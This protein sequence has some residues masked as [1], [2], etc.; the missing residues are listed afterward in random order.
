MES[1]GPYFHRCGTP[2]EKSNCTACAYEEGRKSMEK[3][4]FADE[5]PNNIKIFIQSSGRVVRILIG[6]GYFEQ[7]NQ[8]AAQRILFSEIRKAITTNREAAEKEARGIE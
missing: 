6:E 5:L 3:F 1:E 8:E 2:G 7:D 4:Y